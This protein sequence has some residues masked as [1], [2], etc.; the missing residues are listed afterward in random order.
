[1][2]KSYP[3]C[4]TGPTEGVRLPTF[5]HMYVW[6]ENGELLISRKIPITDNNAIPLGHS[7]G[8]GMYI[9]RWEGRAI[10]L[11]VY[12]FEPLASCLVPPKYT[13]KLLMALSPCTHSGEWFFSDKMYIDLK[14]RFCL[15]ENF[16]DPDA[17]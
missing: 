17:I 1:M 7:Y 16:G 6:A 3:M 5:A 9:V 15:T 10:W 11:R 12:S 4:C 8:H 13:Q 2:S 14:Y